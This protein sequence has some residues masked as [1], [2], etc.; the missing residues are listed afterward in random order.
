MTVDV[1]DLFAEEP[2]ASVS[3]W[4]VLQTLLRFRLDIQDFL[5]LEMLEDSEKAVFEQ[6][7]YAA[8]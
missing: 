2:A 4:T 3:H 1:T 8:R 5:I 7:R 6:A